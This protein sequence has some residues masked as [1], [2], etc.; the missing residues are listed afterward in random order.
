MN[1]SQ[2]LL[3]EC[4]QHHCSLNATNRCLSH[5][6]KVWNQC[7][8]LFHCGWNL[9]IK[10][11]IEFIKTTIEV[12]DCLVES[13]LEEGILY[14]IDREYIEF[15]DWVRDMKNKIKELQHN[16]KENEFDVHNTFYYVD[17]W[18]KINKMVFESQPYIILYFIHI[19]L[20][21]FY[22]SC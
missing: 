8:V 13:I 20:L 17:E 15:E 2:P 22:Y 4:E 11:G 14:R 16:I 5:M 3:G 9:R 12:M 18:I 1:I 7:A 19:A 6:R 21:I 10:E